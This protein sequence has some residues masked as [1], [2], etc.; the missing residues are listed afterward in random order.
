[1]VNRKYNIMVLKA[2]A[3]D[4]TEEWIL[5]EM[6]R[7]SVEPLLDWSR[8]YPDDAVT[9]TKHINTDE[10]FYLDVVVYARTDDPAIVAHLKLEFDLP[11]DKLTWKL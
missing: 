4:S 3:N 7:D 10:H 5:D 2:P 6:V 8:Q 11:I 1:M 9:F